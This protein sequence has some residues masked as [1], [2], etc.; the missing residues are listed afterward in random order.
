MGGFGLQGL[1]VLF[2]FDPDDYFFF[3]Q[4]LQNKFSHSPGR[5]FIT[6]KTN[7]HI[8]LLKDKL[9]DLEV[10]GKVQTDD[11]IITNGTSAVA[12]IGPSTF[13]CGITQ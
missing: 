5:L 10:Q 3:E 6:A 11:S 7:L 1:A 13:K 9:V 8:D 4:N 12:G 2:V